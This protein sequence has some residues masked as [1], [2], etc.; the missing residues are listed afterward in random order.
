MLPGFPKKVVTTKLG[1]GHYRL[2]RDDGHAVEAQRGVKGWWCNGVRKA[3]S[4]KDI[5]LD[6]Q[7]GYTAHD[8]LGET[9]SK[10]RFLVEWS[11]EGSIEV[12]LPEDSTEE[13]IANA[14]REALY[15]EARASR[16]GLLEDINIHR[17][18]GPY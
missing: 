7:N 5:R 3:P 14:A 18:T 9:M 4:L 11:M 1:R 10:S 17:H 13:Q 6:M 12:E 2:V 8:Q 15:S 16:G